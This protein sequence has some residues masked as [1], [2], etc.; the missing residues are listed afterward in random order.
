MN[1][2][3]WIE[4]QGDNAFSATSSDDP[5]L[6]GL[7]RQQHLKPPPLGNVSPRLKKYLGRGSRAVDKMF[8]KV[9][10]SAEKE[11]DYGGCMF[12]TDG[13]KVLLL[14]RSP[15]AEHAPGKWG[16]VCGHSIGEETP[17][18]TA[19][20]EAG[21][22]IGKVQGERIGTLGE[23]NKYPVH[24]FKVK[25]PFECKLNDENDEWEWI[26]FEDLDDYD[27]HPLFKRSMDSY[28]KLVRQ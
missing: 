7:T 28:I 13:K 14:K 15:Y 25:I 27:L 19:R 12:F 18:A 20:R 11:Q 26:R 22:E 10:E 21:E 4:G 2:K 6:N 23:N 3:K 17:L 9:Q 24:I 8:G 16:L 5:E 1:F